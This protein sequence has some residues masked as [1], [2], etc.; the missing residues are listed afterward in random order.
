MDNLKLEALLNQKLNPQLIKDY[1]PN[2]LQVEGRTEIK[3][4]V[5]G[6]TA[7]QALIEQ[8]IERN[9]DALLVHHGYFWKSEPESIRGMKGHRIRALIRNDINLYA[10]HLPLDIHPELGNNKL[11]ADLLGIHVDGGLE[12]HPQ[13]VA[14]F[15]HFEQALTADELSQRIEQ[16]LQRRPL[17]VAPSSNRIIKT[18]GWCTG[19]GQDFVDLAAQYGLDAFISGEISERTTYSARE[20]NI[21]YFSAGHHATER[22]GVKALGEWLASEYGFEVEFID[23]NNPV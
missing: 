1:C 3:K 20:Q 15:G 12:G 16:A 10:Y 18:V 14:M 8:A 17:H 5:T 21:H 13:S 7:S 9:A 2:G 6:V 11:L 4:I 22:Y 19:G 23:I